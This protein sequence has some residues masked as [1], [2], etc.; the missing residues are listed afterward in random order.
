MEKPARRADECVLCGR[1]LT[2]DEIAVTKKL[3][4]RGAQS[5]FCVPC[6]AARFKITEEDVYGLIENFKVAGCSLFS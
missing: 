1:A 4:N 2:S 6:L 3:I 5:F